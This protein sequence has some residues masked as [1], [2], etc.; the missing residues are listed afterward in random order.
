[1]P[2]HAHTYAYTCTYIHTDARLLTHAD[3]YT[4][5]YTHDT[6]LATHTTLLTHTLDTRY[7]HACLH[8]HMNTNGLRRR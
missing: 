1:M 5:G 6:P 2:T 4:L 3:R 8:V 7:T